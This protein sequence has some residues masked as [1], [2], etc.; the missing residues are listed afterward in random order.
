MDTDNE[1]VIKDVPQCVALTY[2]ERGS[3]LVKCDISDYEVVLASQLLLD[4]CVSAKRLCVC[5]CVYV[6][7]E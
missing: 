2:L 4:E 3:C 1:R 5:V 6:C 7:V